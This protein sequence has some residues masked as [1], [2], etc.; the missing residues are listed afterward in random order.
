M[1]KPAPTMTPMSSSARRRLTERDVRIA[2]RDLTRP[3]D[4]EAAMDDLT[5]RLRAIYCRPGVDACQ[6]KMTDSYLHHYL[7]STEAWHATPRLKEPL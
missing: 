5:T 3:E 6:L 7:D 2:M 4:R 1:N